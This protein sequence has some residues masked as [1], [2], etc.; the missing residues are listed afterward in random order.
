R[1]S[2][3]KSRPP[4]GDGTVPPPVSLPG[5]RFA[6]S[7]LWSRAR[8][9]ARLPSLPPVLAGVA[10][11][12][13]LPLTCGRAGITTGGLNTGGLRFG[14]CQSLI[15]HLLLLL[16]GPLNVLI[17][18]ERD[19]LVEER[20]VDLELLRHLPQRVRDLRQGV[21]AELRPADL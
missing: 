20:R 6:R 1:S 4:R 5:Q 18:E 21:R 15:L 8:R 14:H 17:G 9:R 7:T 11:G 12:P 13:C 2:W 19:V 3:Q 10:G 16:R